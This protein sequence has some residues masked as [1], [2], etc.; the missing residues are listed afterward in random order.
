MD[1]EALRLVGN[2]RRYLTNP[3]LHKRLVQRLTR[4]NGDHFDPAIIDTNLEYAEA[5][6]DIARHHPEVRT[7][8]EVD[9]PP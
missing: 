8:K 4:L 1:E 7:S 2:W 5:L 3:M 9:E 6:N